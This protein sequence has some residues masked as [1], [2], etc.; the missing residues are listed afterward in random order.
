MQLNPNYAVGHQWY[1]EYLA[2]RGRHEE[3]IAA[4][5]RALDLDPLSLIIH[6]TLGRHGYYF[7]RQYERAAEQLHKTLEME[8][9]FW[10]AYHFL[11]AVYAC[12]GRLEEARTAFETAHRLDGNLEILAGLGHVHGLAGRRGEALALLDELQ[13]L[14][15]RC[16]VSPILSAVIWTGLGDCD[17]AFA[18]LDRA[19]EDRTQWLSEILVDSFFDR[20]RPDPRFK[21]LLRRVGLLA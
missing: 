4:I 9:N 11:G 20:L 16:Y 7:A 14:S 6:A 3:A 12:M 10:V 19:V 1:G 17:Q 15:A 8:A 13:R 18:W 2:A 5:G 21:D